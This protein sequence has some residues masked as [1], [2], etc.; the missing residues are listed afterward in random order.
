MSNIDKQDN[1]EKFEAWAEEVGALP[2]GY[3]K[4][5]R[6]ASGNY[7]VQIYNYMWH[8]WNAC[9]EALL[10]ELEAAEVRVT[11]LSQKADI[12]DMLRE[13]YGLNGSLVD[14]VD[15]QAK[16]IS[17]LEE[18]QRL[19]DICQGQGLEHRIAAEKRAEDTEKRSERALSLLSDANTEN[20]WDVIGRLKVVIGGDYRSEAEIAAA[21]KGE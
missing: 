18:K 21:G 19:I 14:F 4:K 8:A 20:V 9:Y 5:Q 11:E 15:W 2:W 13:D 12:Y 17:E 10:D 7:S 1:R 6:T 16:R 3:L